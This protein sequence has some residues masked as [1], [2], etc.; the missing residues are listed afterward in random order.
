MKI[1]L[2]DITPR[3]AP[4]IHRAEHALV[5]LV[6]AAAITAACAALLWSL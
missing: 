6:A 5:A 1:H 3:P 2:T 4:I